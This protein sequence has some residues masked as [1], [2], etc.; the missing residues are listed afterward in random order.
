MNKEET[1]QI[2]SVL[3]ISYP[4]SFRDYT[5][6]TGTM[7]LDLWAT[8]FQGTP[9]KLVK[10]AVMDIIAHDNREFAPNPGQIN[11]RILDLYGKNYQQDALEAWE[12]IKGYM[13]SMNWD[14]SDVD[15]YRKL[16]EGIRRYYS[17]GALKDMAMGK[18]RDNDMYEKPKFLRAYAELS[19][20]EDQ[21]LLA[22]GKIAEV[23]GYDK[24]LALEHEDD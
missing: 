15:R 23:I 3:R 6:A 16:P 14:T 8:V 5:E 24:Y 18:S 2:L 1:R 17:Y 10:A 9:A 12:T 13:R 22:E 4:Q 20:A 11:Q 19:E 21:K 7:L